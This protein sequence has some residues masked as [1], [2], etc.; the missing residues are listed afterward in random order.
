MPAFCEQIGAIV[1][2]RAFA[3]ERQAIQLAVIGQPVAHRLQQVVDVVGR[4]QIVHRRQ[5][6]LLGPDRHLVV[7]DRQ[8]S[9]WPA[10]VAMSVVTR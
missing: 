3:V 10:L 2:H 4:R 5:P 8:M 7:A 6:A 1:G 9:N